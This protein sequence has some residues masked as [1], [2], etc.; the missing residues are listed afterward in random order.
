MPRERSFP[1][2]TY[3]IFFTP[4]SGSYLLCE[5]LTTSGLQ[6]Q[7]RQSSPECNAA[8][9][10]ILL[11]LGPAE[12]SRL[13]PVPGRLNYRGNES[14][15]L[16]TPW[17]AMPSLSGQKAV[18]GH[19]I[20]DGLNVVAWLLISDPFGRRNQSGCTGSP[21]HRFATGDGSVRTHRLFSPYDRK[22]TTIAGI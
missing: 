13:K 10:Q 15:T 21:G 22:S 19:S 2:T 6:Q 3:L 16:G 9:G 20:V 8:F 5:A 4:R 12:S 18:C 14:E 11:R 1:H 17:T 7:N